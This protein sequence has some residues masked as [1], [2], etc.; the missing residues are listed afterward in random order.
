MENV[1]RQ[2]GPVGLPCRDTP[3]MQVVSLLEGLWRADA[4]PDYPRSR[5]SF[6]A[7]SP[8]SNI[9]A[10]VGDLQC[11]FQYGR[12]PGDKHEGVVSRGL[13]PDEMLPGSKVIRQGEAH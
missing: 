13:T 6:A 2:D 5:W 10:P 3:G 4:S 7:V 11:D 12:I 9:V 8:F 1:C